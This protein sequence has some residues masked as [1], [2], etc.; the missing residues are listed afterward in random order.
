MKGTLRLWVVLLTLAS[1]AGTASADPKPATKIAE[2]LASVAVQHAAATSKGVVFRSVDPF[3]PAADDWVTIDAVAAGDPGALAA[4]LKGLGAQ[5]VA[6]FGRIVSARLPIPAISTLDILPTLRFAQPAY[7]ATNAGLVTSQGDRA[8]R[9]D[10]AR[11][12]LG[13]TGAGVRVG[14]LSDSFNCRGGAATDVATGDLSPVTVLLEEPG[15]SSGTDEGRAMLQIVHDV[16]PGADLAF[17]TAFAG[18]ASFAANIRALATAGAR[19][20]VDDVIYLTEPMFQD[21]VIAQSVDSVVVQGVA[22]FSSAGNNARQSYDHAFVAGGMFPAGAFGAGFSGGIA[23]DFGGGDVFQRITV[24]PATSFRLVLQWDSPFFS[25]GGTGTP[26]DVDV[27]ILNTAATQILASATTNNIG[28]GDPVELVSFANPG[29]TAVDVNIMIVTRAG[30]NPGRIKYVLFGG[31]RVVIQQFATNSGTIY[32]HA[33]AQSAIAVGAAFYGQTPEFGVNPPILESFSSGGTTPILFNTAGARLGAADPRANKPQIVAPD[34][35]DTTFFFRDT[36]GNGF[37]NFFGTSAAAPHAAA[38]AALILEAAPTVTPAQVLAALQSTARDMAPA[39]FDNDSGFGLI[40]ADAALLSLA[41]VTGITPTP[42]DL[43]SPPA[44]F[45]ISGEIFGNRGFGLP[46]V[47]FT[48]G[49]VVLAQARATALTG[50]TALTVP[51]PT[52]ATSLGGAHSGLSAGAVDVQVYD[53]TGPST[54]LL[55]GSTPLTVADTRSCTLCVTGITPSSIDLATPPAAFSVAG[56][57]FTSGGFGRPVVN[58]T[59]GGVVLAQARA[60]A[61]TG[62][63]ALTVPFPTDATSLGGPHSGLS[64]G[65]VDVQVYNQTGPSAYQLVGSIPLTVTDTRPCTLCVTGITPSSIDLATPPAAFSVAGQG[66]ANAG[67]GLPV[68]NFTRGGV[69]LAQARATALTGGL[70]LTVPFPPDATSLGGPHSGLS[71]GA[72]DVQVYNQ[73][74][75]SAYQLVGST[76]FTVTDTRPPSQVRFL[77]DL[78]ICN[79][80]CQSFTA[81]LT[82]HEGYTW[83]AVSSSLRRGSVSLV[84]STSPVLNATYYSS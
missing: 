29:A 60:T 6:V 51:F 15:C 25:V 43:A 66:F 23:H 45:T 8:M 47:N 1:A 33:N 16:A 39:G 26:N 46:A 19:V 5:H 75:P 81:R 62:G 48:R 12:T 42:I 27:Y 18:L 54:Y 35:G 50:S 21:G 58:F 11:A 59:R 28:S 13:V 57:G 34:G 68:A 41:T 67:F 80:G 56:Q 53:Q 79:P 71:A 69:V 37:P 61:L 14:V 74:G 17:A 76:P 38:V 10:I 64:A 20:I 70:T 30:P 49:G 22:Y 40:Q 2:D 73:T 84:P 32:G 72:V 9:A 3:L 78:T 65:A 82:A 4:D 83:L 55:I 31:N 52:D 77:N 44:T 7:S 36:D 63:T 24:P